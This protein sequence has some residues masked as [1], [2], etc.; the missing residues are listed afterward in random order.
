MTK[1]L[2]ITSTRIGDAILSM[3]LLDSMLRT[4]PDPHFT[5]VCGGLP[6]SL[7]EGVPSLQR[8]IILKKKKY[9]AHWFDLWC[10]LR[11]EKFDVIVDLRDSIISRVISAKHIY[12]FGKHIN[13]KAHKVI[14]NAEVMK[15]ES[16]PSP[17]LFLT[18]AQKSFAATLMN[19]Q[20]GERIIGIGPTAN[21]I[22]KTWD[23]DRFVELIKHL[24]KDGQV[25]AGAR[26]A[27]FAAPGEEEAAHY[28]LNTIPPNRQINVIAK[29]NPA[30]AAACIALCDLYI[31]NDSG[32]MHAAAAAGVKTFGLFGASYVHIYGPYGAHTAYA[33]TPQSFD[34]LKDFAGYD[35]KTLRHSLM[36]GLTTATVIKQIDEFIQKN[37]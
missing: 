7:F 24:T 18:D 25:F 21:W 11:H 34:E 35:P 27:I 10:T 16:V 15:L 19:K 30:E 20:E 29:G 26:V 2:F 13:R 28:V 3:G 4:M 12:R 23:K 6:A 31:G 37:Y 36:D 22:G 33:H 9:H 1:I 17:R 32:L 5:I 8:L 14:Q